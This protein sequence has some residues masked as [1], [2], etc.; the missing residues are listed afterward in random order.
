MLRDNKTSQNLGSDVQEWMGVLPNNL[1]KFCAFV[2]FVF[3]YSD[4]GVNQILLKSIWKVEGRF[5][6]MSYPPE[7]VNAIKKIL[8]EELVEGSRTGIWRLVTID[9]LRSFLEHINQIGK[10]DYLRLRRNLY[11]CAKPQAN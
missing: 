5:S 10:R 4:L 8:I 6:I 1:V 7:V 9:F 3:K 2:G 11:L